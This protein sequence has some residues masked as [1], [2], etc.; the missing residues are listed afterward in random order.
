MALENEKYML[1][2]TFRR[3]GTAVG[4]P[5]WLVHLPDGEIGFTTGATSGKVK[6]LKHTPRVTL[7]ACD[8]RGQGL[9]G[10]VLEGTARAV[11]GGPEVQQ[12]RAAVAEKYGLMAKVLGVV[13]TVA[14]KAGSQRFG[15]GRAAVIVALADA[16]AT[17]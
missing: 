12:M 3:D 15:S 8:R 10:P 13:E 2:T 4:T 16:G 5:V 14:T 17:A 11:V 1:F 7:Q 9:H 6:R